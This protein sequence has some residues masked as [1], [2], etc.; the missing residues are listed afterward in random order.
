MSLLYMKITYHINFYY[1]EN[2]IHYLFKII[3]ECSKYRYNTDIF[4]HTNIDFQITNLI[5][6]DNGIVKLI[7]HDIS[8][9]NPYKLTWMCRETMKKQINDCQ[10]TL[11][12]IRSKTSSSDEASSVLTKFLIS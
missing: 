1:N 4:I 6:Y 11:T 2:R 12:Q 5:K 10:N 9:M 3:N 8:K 7:V